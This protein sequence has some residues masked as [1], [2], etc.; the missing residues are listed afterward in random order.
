MSLQ[1]L[2][3]GLLPINTNSVI[4]WRYILCPSYV[5]DSFYA[6]VNLAVNLYEYLGVTSNPLITLNLLNKKTKNLSSS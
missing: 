5:S 1:S 6:K 2:N 3:P 4:L